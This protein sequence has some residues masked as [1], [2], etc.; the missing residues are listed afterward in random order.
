M[1]TPELKWPMTNLTPS[2]TNLLATDT[3]CFGSDTS[4]PCSSSIFWP[5]MPPAL[6]MS[7]TACWV[8][9]TSCAPNAA[10]G[11]VI[12]PATPN[13]IWALAAPE[14]ARA[15]ASATPDNQYFFMQFHSL[16]VRGARPSQSRPAAEPNPP[17]ARILSRF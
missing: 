14:N 9:L 4:S 8:P 17:W 13:L 3:P 15:A 1:V 11:P 5:R 6:L 7:S 2:P 16:E 12:G 10:L